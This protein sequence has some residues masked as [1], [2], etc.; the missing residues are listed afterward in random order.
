MFSKLFLKTP[1]S[2]WVQ[3]TPQSSPKRPEIK[4]PNEENYDDLNL[5]QLC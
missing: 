4:S 1:K 3:T 5:E 2:E